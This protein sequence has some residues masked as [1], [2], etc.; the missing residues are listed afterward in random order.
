MTQPPRKPYR[1]RPSAPPQAGLFPDS[2]NVLAGIVERIRFRADDTGFSVLLVQPDGDFPPVAVVGFLSGIREGERVEFEGEWGDHPRFGRQFKATIANPII[3]TTSDGI[4]KFLASGTVKNI[5]PALAKRI[6]SLFG[7]ASLEIIENEPQRLLEVPGL[8]K[9]KL[10]GVI[11]SWKKQSEVKEVLLFLQNFDIP[12]YLA[13]K[14]FRVYGPNATQMLRE[15]PYRLATDIYGVGFRTADRIAQ[16]MGISKDAPGR[17]AAGILYVLN[18]LAEREGHIFVPYRVLI[19]ETSKILDISQD[20]VESAIETLHRNGGV[21]IESFGHCLLDDKQ[22]LETDSK[23]N[24][25]AVYSQAF[26]SAESEVARRMA[27]LAQSQRDEPRMEAALRGKGA[28][29]DTLPDRLSAVAQRS[30]EGGMATHDQARAIEGA[31]TKKVLIVTG[32]PGTGKTTIVDAV[33]KLYTQLG[34]TV[35]LGAPTGRAAKRLTEI[36]KHE[37]RTIHRMLEFSWTSGGFVRDASQPLSADVVV[38]D[39]AS[40]VDIH[41]MAHL[42]RAVPDSASFILVG[43]VDQLPSVGPGN[44]LRDLIDSNVVP[45]IRLQEV[46]RQA[47]ESFIVENA[48]RIN[49]GE[50]PREPKGAA[51][52]DLRD[53]YFIEENDAERCADILIELCKERIRERFG[54]DPIDDVQVISPM[55]RGSLGVQRLNVQLQEA[56]NPPSKIPSIKSGDRTFRQGDKLIQIRNNYEK[57]V[58]NGDI[59]I[60]RNIDPSAGSITVEYDSGRVEYTKGSLDEVVHAYAVT[61]H[62][63]QGSEYPAVVIPLHTQHYPM[64]QRNLVYTALTRA[65]R[66]AVFIGSKKALGMAIKNAKVRRR[67]SHLAERTRSF[68]GLPLLPKEEVPAHPE[69]DTPEVATEEKESSSSWDERPPDH[70]YENEGGEEDEDDFPPLPGELTYHPLEG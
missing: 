27:T 20:L 37:A 39:E 30:L 52:E 36:T 6:V 29:G 26:H 46:F 45:V 22:E 47:K 66:L 16:K 21:V 35:L 8:G 38:I 44:V 32:G 69:K 14:I 24:R 42:L 7:E 25:K 23:N 5:G 33:T 34:L 55:Q 2:G 15:D 11:E 4:E 43:D 31:L 51:A 62:K 19:H 41:L 40:M 49:R 64:L 18:Q 48:H 17:C 28:H 58:F 57:N 9:K 70:I 63:S 56:L 12:L 54:L 61:V 68:A 1:P 67:W 50:M 13:E 53:Y 59:G 60:I 10:T 65:K 3:P